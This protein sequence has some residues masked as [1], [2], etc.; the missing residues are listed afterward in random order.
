M[1][2]LSQEVLDSTFFLFKSKKDAEQC[3]DAVGTGF[4]VGM[5]SPWPGQFH[6]Y[7]VTNWHVAIKL[8]GTVIGLSKIKGGIDSIETEPADWFW[9]PK[10]DDLAIIPL[11]VD[12]SVHRLAHIERNLFATD[13]DITRS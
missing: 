2:R 7:A 4:I 8:G 9:D 10:G 13:R 3:K 6:L 11:A 12:T 5:P 1:P